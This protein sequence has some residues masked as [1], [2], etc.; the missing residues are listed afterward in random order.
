MIKYSFCKR[1][2]LLSIPFFM[3]LSCNSGNQDKEFAYSEFVDLDSF[4]VVMPAE[5]LQT[6]DWTTYKK[7]SQ[8]ILVEYGL[9]GEGVFIIH[10]V[11]FNE[12]AYVKTISIPKDGPDGYNSSGASVFMK[13]EDSL[14]LFPMG[15]DSFFLYNSLGEKKLEYKYNSNNLDNYYKNEF[16]SGMISKNGVLILPTINDVRYDDPD[17]FKKVTPIQSF[18]LNTSKFVDKIEYP[19]FTHGKYLSPLSGATVSTIDEDQFL[20]NYSFSD[21]IYIYNDKTNVTSSFYCGSD[22]FGKPKLLDRVFSRDE[23]MVYVVKEVN[24]ELAFYHNSKIYRIVNHISARDYREKS[25]FEI[26]SENR[27]GVS[28]VELNPNT[29][30]LK[31]YKLPITKYFVFQGNFLFAGGVSIREDENETYRR[32]YKYTLE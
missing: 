6:T 10:Q 2:W 17:Y 23:R 22:F 12:E 18:D 32:F 19:E 24:Y 9:Y 31:Y 13:S 25:V 29:G 14:Y 15:R 16:F 11:D 28:L 30:E 3:F 20:I 7:G 4:E 26:L 21:S 1:D 5:Y 8:T 27:R